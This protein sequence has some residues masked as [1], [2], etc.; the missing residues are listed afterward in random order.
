MLHSTVCGLIL[1]LLSCLVAWSVLELV[2]LVHREDHILLR[3]E[4]IMWGVNTNLTGMRWER[5]HL[6]NSGGKVAAPRPI[7]QDLGSQ[8][9]I[10]G[11]IILQISLFPN[12]AVL[13][14]GGSK[15]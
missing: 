2:V 8:L 7:L 14:C 6:R 3:N 15:Y 12:S 9:L 13:G 4:G 5:A 1:W 10:Q 11:I